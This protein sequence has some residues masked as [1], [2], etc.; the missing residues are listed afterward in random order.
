M[1]DDQLRVAERRW[2]ETRAD[3]DEA[4][5][6]L[7][8][9]RAG[10]LE[11]SKL[12]RCAHFGYRPAV[13]AMGVLP[14]PLESFPE[15]LVQS[16]ESSPEGLALAALAAAKCAFIEFYARQRKKLKGDV[17]SAHRLWE[18][19]GEALVH[20]Q[21]DQ[22]FDLAL[23]SF[24]AYFRAY[25]VRIPQSPDGTPENRLRAMVAALCIPRLKMAAQSQQALQVRIGR[26]LTRM[27]Y[28]DQA[29]E[30]YGVK[31][32]NARFEHMLEEFGDPTP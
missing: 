27:G 16:L 4:H 6:L 24:Y 2:R 31:R 28:H 9:V 20:K 17:Q 11:E 12:T 29:Q 25:G 10:Q 5:Y 1:S 7:E 14:V 15:H 13:L 30:A 21:F 3:E 18:N 26:W 32:A 19:A 22:G 23:R 8:I